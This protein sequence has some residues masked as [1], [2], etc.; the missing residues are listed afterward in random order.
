MPERRQRFPVGR[1]SAPMT[2]D[3]AFGTLSLS[4]GDGA[5]DE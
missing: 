4:G 5:V 3:G 2:R 1:D